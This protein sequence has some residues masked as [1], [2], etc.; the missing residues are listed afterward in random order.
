MHGF[1]GHQ[2]QPRAAE[3]HYHHPVLVMPPVI[4]MGGT[5]ISGYGGDEYTVSIPPSPIV[6]MPPS[7]VPSQVGFIEF[8]DDDTINVDVISVEVRRETKQNYFE[9]VFILINSY[10]FFFNSFYLSLLLLLKQKQ[11]PLNVSVVFSIFFFFGL[12]FN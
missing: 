10:I 5:N 12:P 8:P 4:L 11:K 7:P 9:F 3:N 2:E 1:I 6:E